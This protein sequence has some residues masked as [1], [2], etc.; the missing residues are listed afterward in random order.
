MAFPD[1]F[2][3]HYGLGGDYD[4]GISSRKLPSRISS[5]PPHLTPDL[6][7]TDFSAAQPTVTSGLLPTG[8]LHTDRDK[9]CFHEW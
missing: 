5:G 1:L 3:S 4:E 2:L 9:E 7:L 6:D 8:E